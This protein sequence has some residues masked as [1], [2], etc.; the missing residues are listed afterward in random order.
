MGLFDFR[1]V[2]KRK[3]KKD[4]VIIACTPSGILINDTPISFPTNYTILKNI[5]GEA[6]RIEPI[7]QTK[8]NVYLWDDLGIYCSTA[9]AQKMLMILLVEDNR[10][11]LGHQPKSNF[12][13]IVTIDDKPIAENIQNV[14]QDRPYMIRSINKE[15][16]QVAIAL[17][18]NPG[19]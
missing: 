3:K 2:N 4:R 18:W 16:N 13:G 10:Y 1:D 15:N 5:L 9:D 19:I 17:G 7:K 6:S 11:G 12:T 8:N 14:S